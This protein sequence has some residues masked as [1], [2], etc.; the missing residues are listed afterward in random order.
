MC[1]I[2]DPKTTNNFNSELVKVI[3][4]IQLQVHVTV[5]E[6]SIINCKFK[7]ILDFCSRWIITKM[8]IFRNKVVS[9]N[10]R[11]IIIPCIDGIKGWWNVGD[12]ETTVYAQIF[13]PWELIVVFTIV[14]CI[15]LRCVVLTLQNVRNKAIG[16]CSCIFNISPMQLH[17]KNHTQLCAGDVILE[18][19]G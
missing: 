14:V 13:Y 17:C 12:C 11:V 19:N 15:L 5:T 3:S 8:N 9:G 18:M 1:S 6:T 7:L 2:S 4:T 10:F 16:Q